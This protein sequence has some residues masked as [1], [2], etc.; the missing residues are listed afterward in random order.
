[1]SLVTEIKAFTAKCAESLQ[2][3][4]EEFRK[5]ATV[6]VNKKIESLRT[7]CY[8]DLAC[9]EPGKQTV[10]EVID[11]IHVL[12][13]AAKEKSFP[14][15]PKSIFC[16]ALNLLSDEK[17]DLDFVIERLKSI[18]HY[19]Q[20]PEDRIGAFTPLMQPVVREHVLKAV[21]KIQDLAEPIVYAAA[22]DEEV[23]R[24]EVKHA[25]IAAALEEFAPY[26]DTV[27]D[28]KKLLDTLLGSISRT[29]D[30]QATALFSCYKGILLEE[31]KESCVQAFKTRLTIEDGNLPQFSTSPKE[32]VRKMQR[33]ISTIRLRPSA[34]RGFC[35]KLAEKN[36]SFGELLAVF[37]EFDRGWQ[38]ASEYSLE[39]A[40]RIFSCLDSEVVA[41]QLS[42][43]PQEKT[44][45][46]VDVRNWPI[47]LQPVKR[48]LL[49][50]TISPIATA[51]GEVFDDRGVKKDAISSGKL[52]NDEISY[53]TC[54]RQGRRKTMEDADL[55]TTIKLHDGTTCP[56]FAV[57]DGHCGD[58]VAGLVQ[59]M[60]PATV[61][62]WLNAAIQENSQD[63]DL[64]IRNAMKIGMIKLNSILRNLGLNDPLH[65]PGATCI[66]S[67]IYKDIL[68]TVNIGDSR[69]V[70]SSGEQ[71]SIDANKHSPA[72][73]EKV[74][75]RDGQMDEE[76]R[77]EG[78]LTFSS[79]GNFHR[80]A[81]I[82]T[83]SGI[84]ALRLKRA[85]EGQSMK[86]LLVCD[87]ITSRISSLGLIELLKKHDA[88][89]IV[90]TAY[91][92]GAED[93]LTAIVASLPYCPADSK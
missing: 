73:V 13:K 38:K 35:L 47:H 33:Y 80:G 10:R 24:W 86:L 48:E 76:G 14:S 57:I 67:F 17:T 22:I 93:N 91:D 26:F 39:E 66:F 40:K 31:S 43:L 11:K 15:I 1:M 70:T 30:E 18:P 54:A 55:V 16:Q 3:V 53:S 79:F 75:K 84:H 12:T 87:G 34:Y 49:Y 64:A 45:V 68:Y 9:L 51:T 20:L 41:K 42:L 27:R 92:N 71:L 44:M 77:I 7:K 90:Q 56:L 58:L 59:I 4:P 28:S 23:S 62:T 81:S 89:D 85:Q 83:F 21:E 19:L 63:I 78:L 52:L 61:Q 74:K 25:R 36:F 88:K 29:P 37:D 50:Q 72:H 2:A 5:E 6:V 8:S 60:L 46:C 82:T 65:V 69:A 32:N